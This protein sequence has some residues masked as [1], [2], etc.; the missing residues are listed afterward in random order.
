M[1]DPIPE[2]VVD[3]VGE[4]RRYVE[5]AKVLLKEH[6]DLDYETQLNHRDKEDRLFVVDRPGNLLNIQTSRRGVDD[7]LIDTTLLVN[8]VGIT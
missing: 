5:N 4:A 1:K 2:I 3:P 8:L 6:G 7:I